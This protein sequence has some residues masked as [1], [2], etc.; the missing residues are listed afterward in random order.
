MAASFELTPGRKIG[1]GEPCYVVG[2]V[3]QNHNGRI[4]LA[5]RLVEGVADARADA[6]KFCKRHIPSDLARRAYH[7]AYEGSN[8]FG[9]TYGEHREFLELTNQQHAELKRKA[10]S[11]E[12]T[13]FATACD[14]HSVDALESAGAAF[15]KIA[16]RDLINLPLLDYVAGTGKPVVLS[17]GMDVA[18]AIGEAL[19]TVRRHHDRVLLLQCTSAY[20]TEF[21]DV[22]LRAMQ[23]LQERFDVLTGLSDHTPGAAIAA[24]AAALGAVMIEK[25]VTLDRKMKG[26]DHACSLELEAFAD[27][28]RGVRAVE[29][30]LGDGVKRVPEAVADARQ[31]LGR[32][33]V[34]KFRVPRGTRLTE[35]MLCLKT[36]GE[37]VSWRQRKHLIGKIARRDIPQDEQVTHDDVG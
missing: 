34:T 8:S 14:Q 5:R 17:C 15:Y 24:A 4:D 10:E 35:S 18:Q 6:V 32:Y 13:Y 25:H 36:S 12:L 2:E 23:T 11:R 27:M 21:G 33:V 20:P 16:S 28:V 26:T 19:D 30:A 1:P 7:R 31:R 22:N 3:G 29:A 9:N 37:G